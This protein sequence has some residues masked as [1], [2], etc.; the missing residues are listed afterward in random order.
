MRR[1]VRRLDTYKSITIWH[2]ALGAVRNTAPKC[3]AESETF[4]LANN[5]GSEFGA[6]QV[7]RTNGKTFES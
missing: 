4:K 3:L 7:R 5:R 1:P 2:G 6:P